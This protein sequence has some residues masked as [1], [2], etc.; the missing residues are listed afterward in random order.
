MENG[1]I[2]RLQKIFK[3]K[4]IQ[5]ERHIINIIINNNDVIHVIH[6]NINSR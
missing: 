3:S 6:K 2:L 4:I 1:G 5:I